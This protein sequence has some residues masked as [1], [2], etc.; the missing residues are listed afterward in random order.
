MVLPAKIVGESETLELRVGDGEMFS[1][2]LGD[3]LP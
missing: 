1:I 2:R 3:L